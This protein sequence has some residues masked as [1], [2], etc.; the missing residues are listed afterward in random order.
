MS[1]V[2]QMLRR[3]EDRKIEILLEIGD[4]NRQYG[5]RVS[6]LRAEYDRLDLEYYTLRFEQMTTRDR[7]ASP[8]GGG[9]Q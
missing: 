9:E 8:Q 5:E 2:D 7:A 3:I 4:I 1:E 6:V